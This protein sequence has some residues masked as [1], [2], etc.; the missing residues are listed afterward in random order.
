MVRVKIAPDLEFKM[1]I[2]LEGITIDSRDHDVQQ[3]KKE[4]VEAFLAQLRKGFQEKDIKL[5]TFAFALDLEKE[6]KFERAA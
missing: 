1:N 4:V 5:D 3:H 6:G 2:E